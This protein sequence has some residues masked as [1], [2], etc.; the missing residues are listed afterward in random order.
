MKRDP[1]VRFV[2]LSLLL[3]ASAPAGAKAY[4]CIVN[5]KTVFQDHPCAAPAP[6]TSAAAPTAAVAAPP[7]AQRSPEQIFDE[8]QIVERHLR[9]LETTHQAEAKV[10]EPRLAAMDAK[11]RQAERQQME[12]RWRQPV[13][14]QQQKLDRLQTELHTRCPGGAGARSGRFE[15]LP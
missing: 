13:R 4:K 2:L 11:A 15:C 6:A 10:A 3:I 12:A 14:V 1:A 7:A 8:I 9:E 5:G